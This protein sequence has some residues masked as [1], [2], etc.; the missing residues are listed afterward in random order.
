MA[1]KDQRGGGKDKPIDDVWEFES[2]EQRKLM[3]EEV[4]PENCGE[5]LKLIHEI[6]G[7]SR[8]EL[9][10]VLG[11]SES[12]IARLERG[13]SKATK[14]FMLRLAGLAA[15]GYAKYGKMSEKE[16]KNISK[17]IGTA[18]GVAAG[19]GGA[20]GAVS[21]AGTIGG[22]SAAGITSGLSALGG[23]MLGGIAVVA[24]IPVAV[25]FAGFGLVKGIKKI[26][27]ANKLSCK[28]VDGRFEIVPMVEG[29]SGDG[30]S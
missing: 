1:S 12:T 6:T 8:R 4:T 3:L 28:E 24:T 20:I 21:A 26:C 13:E 7:A 22:L 5:K 15:I 16:K 23:T 30:E 19:V 17:Y 10:K 18:G 2:E 29:D 27:E 9:A 25:G 14:E 11:V